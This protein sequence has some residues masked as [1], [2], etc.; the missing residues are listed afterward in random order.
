M[1]APEW[2]AAIGLVTRRTRPSRSY[3]DG[4]GRRILVAASDG[5]ATAFLTDVTV[6]LFV[7]TVVSGETSQQR[8]GARQADETGRKWRS[9]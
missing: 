1:V 3:R 8:Q 6:V 5:I 4:G 2:S 7:K 9:P